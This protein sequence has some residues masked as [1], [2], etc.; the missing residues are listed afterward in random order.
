[1]TKQVLRHLRV[2]P[3]EEL[4][5]RIELYIHEVNASPSLLRW[6]GLNFHYVI[7]GS[8]NLSLTA[9][10]TRLHWDEHCPLL[11]FWNQE[12]F[13]ETRVSGI[14]SRKIFLV[15]FSAFGGDKAVRA[16]PSARRRYF[17][18]RRAGAQG[19]RGTR[20]DHSAIDALQVLLGVAGYPENSV[21]VAGSCGAGHIKDVAHSVERY[22][23]EASDDDQRS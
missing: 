18:S 20:R 17:P 13:E 6:V 21:A 23:G 8:F 1:M 16:S 3:K 10:D 14:M 11:I 9:Q 2:K 12:G 7:S 15:A 19:V 4:K 5:Q 22:G